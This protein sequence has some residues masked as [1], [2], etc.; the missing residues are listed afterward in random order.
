MEEKDYLIYC[1]DE[2]EENRQIFVSRL[3]L[4][5]VGEYFIDDIRPEEKEIGRASCRERV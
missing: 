1:I 3:I 5:S 2:N 4:N